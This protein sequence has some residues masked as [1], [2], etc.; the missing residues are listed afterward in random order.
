MAIALVT[1]P[2]GADTTL[3]PAVSGKIIR[4]R[5]L[6]GSHQLSLVLKS[7]STQ[8]CPMLKIGANG[9]ADIRW[10]DSPMACAR[11][12]ALVGASTAIASTDVW[13]EYEAVD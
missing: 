2:A 3:V 4:L 10:D 12:E 7:A 11:G 5:R 6:L 13:I 9:Y 1:L 8:I